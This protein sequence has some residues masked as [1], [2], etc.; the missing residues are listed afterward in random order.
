MVRPIQARLALVHLR[1]EVINLRH[2]PATD[3][4]L[5]VLLTASQPDAVMQ[6]TLP[7]MMLPLETVLVL[8]ARFLAV[9]GGFGGSLL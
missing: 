4:A 7:V 2:L 3:P 6:C 5:G 8:L 9:V 1:P